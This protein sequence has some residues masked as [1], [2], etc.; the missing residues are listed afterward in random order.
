MFTVSKDKALLTTT[1]GA[2]PRPSWYTENLRGAPLSTGFAHR[3]YRE[4]HFD[5]LACHVAAQYR[6]GIDIMVDGDTRLDDD[7]AGRSWQAYAYERIEGIGSP[8]A[9]VQ[10]APYTAEKRPGDFMWEVIE[11]RMTPHVGGKIGTT[12]LQLDRA[13]KA[14]ASMTDRP[15][16]LGSV[17]AQLVEYMCI[18][19]HYNDRVALLMDLSNALNRE[20]HALADAG[21]PIVQVEE[22][23]VHMTMQYPDSPITP[24]QYVEAFN[25]E[26][27][28]LR[29]K[30]EVWCHTCWGSPGAQRVEHSELS[31]KD[32]LP[33]FD[34]LDIDVLT[35][36][37]A[38]NNGADLEYFGSMISKDKKIALGV[39]S[40][41]TL[42]VER[43]EEVADL[44]RRALKYI[45]PER[46]LLSSDCGFGRQSM[47]RMHAFYK[48]VSLVRGANIVRRE[49]RL[50]ETYIAA[51][52]PKL[53]LVPIEI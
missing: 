24:Q 37:G 15:V 4:Q 2:L 14:I 41:R 51:T 6:A 45:E 8:Q 32:S 49:L 35:V 10:P 34:Q 38:S 13:Y 42:Q 46:L 48:M 36:E 7:V 40:H 44:I 43:P 22:P 29:E 21:A 23:T 11:T 26:V 16:K 12:S 39:I 27:K 53:S 47:S 1:T 28:G 30:C 18:D 17:S 20:Y 19:D 50:E 3:T 9:E 25:R 5:C 31:Y 52:D 33:Y